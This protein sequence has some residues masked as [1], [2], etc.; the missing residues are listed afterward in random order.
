MLTN[1]K[2][3]CCLFKAGNYENWSWAWAATT[4]C[5][6]VF[7]SKNVNFSIIFAALHL[8]HLIL[9]SLTS[10]FQCFFFSPYI[11]HRQFHKRSLVILCKYCNCISFYKLYRVPVKNGQSMQALVEKIKQI[12]GHYRWQGTGVKPET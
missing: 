10:T 2:F 4:N 1:L 7:L 5:S 3:V 6:R 11:L 9:C 8:L 12:V